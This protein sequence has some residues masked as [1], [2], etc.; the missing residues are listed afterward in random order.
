MSAKPHHWLT[1]LVPEPMNYK[2]WKEKFLRRYWNEN[3]KFDLKY[4]LMSERYRKGGAETMCDFATRKIAA[5]K[6]C[7]EGIDNNEL[8]RII[9][10]QL[11]VSIQNLLWNSIPVDYEDLVERLSLFDRTLNGEYER[12]N[13]NGYHDSMNGKNNGTGKIVDNGNRQGN[14]SL[15]GKGEWGNDAKRESKKTGNSYP[16][17]FKDDKRHEQ[18]EINA[19]EQENSHCS[20]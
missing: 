16:R 2:E 1:S 18:I 11:P 15:E 5:F 20:K 17:R 9:I 3:H 19:I 4:K 10:R 13:S 12:N 8:T 14:D 6:A 7:E